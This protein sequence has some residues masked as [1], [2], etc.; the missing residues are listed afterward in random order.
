MPLVMTREAIAAGGS[1]FCFSQPVTYDHVIRAIYMSSGGSAGVASV[2][3]ALRFTSAQTEDQA[4]FDAGI[5]LWPING[6]VTRGHYAANGAFLLENL[7][8]P[9]IG[10]TGKYL[11][12]FGNFSTGMT[13]DASLVLII[14]PLSD[15]LGGTSAPPQDPGGPVSVPGPTPGGGTTPYPTTPTGP[16]DR[17]CPPGF[18]SYRA[19]PW[20][21]DSAPDGKVWCIPMTLML[22]TIRSRTRVHT[23][24]RVFIRQVGK[25]W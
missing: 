24:R 21:F 14:T 10:N 3:H 2:K 1:E 12:R 23:G 20:R 6:E 5:D 19:D 18:T 17:C 16:G 25:W 22:A 7:W 9:V 11:A 8:V 13:A 4:G 15:L